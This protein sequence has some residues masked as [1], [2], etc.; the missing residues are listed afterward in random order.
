M[1]HI[2][3]L[4]FI[5]VALSAAFVTASSASTTALEP[6]SSKKFTW[7]N[8]P[9]QVT[10]DNGGERG[11]QF[12]YNLCNSTT[13]NQQSLCQTMFVNGLDDFCMWSSSQVD[14]TIPESEAREVAWCTQ[15]GHG[16]RVI[17]PGTITGAQWLYAKDYLQVVGFLDQTKVNIDAQDDGGELD[18][19]GDDEQG[20]PLGG[21]VFTNGFGLN[22]ASYQSQFKSGSNGSQSFTQVVEW[23]DFIG[24][25][26]FCLKMCNPAGSDAAH[27]CAHIYDEIG[28]NYNAIANYGAINGSFT[29]CDSDD[30]LDPGVYTSDGIVT[31][32][33]QPFTGTF[34]IPYTTS[35]PSSSN[36]V[37]YQSTDLWAAAATAFP[38]TTT[39]SGSSTATTTSGSSKSTTTGNTSG[40][41]SRTGSSSSGTPS[42]TG[43]S[44]G[45]LNM[46]A[47][48]VFAISFVVAAVFGTMLA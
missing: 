47:N 28:C 46:Q 10:G 12:G 27:L 2:A 38:T 39:T 14:D 35:I 30:M 11:P 4:P 1:S 16:T 6:L 7:P 32:W 26:V 29:V 9:Y 43:S 22:S 5:A 36:C 45:A 20:N 31:T 24:T 21:I 15:P 44:N 25:G 37:T 19:H 23:V 8:I 48:P 17:P 18:P 42:P 13:Q 3:L 41:S 34:S 40:S 33:T